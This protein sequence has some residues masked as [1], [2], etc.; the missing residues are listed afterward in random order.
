MR[1]RLPGELSLLTSLKRFIA[2]LNQLEGNLD[3]PF[4]GLTLLDTI[5]LDRNKISGT[6]PVAVLEHNP[7]LGVLNLGFNQMTGTLPNSLAAA[8]LSHLQLQSNEFLGTIPEAIGNDTRLRKWI[9]SIHMWQT[10]GSLTSQLPI[11][12]EILDLQNN[13]LEGTIPASV[14]DLEALSVFAITN[15]T[16]MN[17]TLDSRVGRLKALTRIEAGNT[18]MMGS[19][20]PELYQLTRLTDIVFG[21]SRMTGPLPE[22]IHLLNATLT[23]LHLQQNT[24]TGP[25]PQALDVLTALEQ[26]WLEENEFTGTISDKVCAERGIGYHK[27]FILNADCNIYCS[28]NDL[29]P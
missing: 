3:D 28:C 26:L 21:N 17:G 7:N 1:G 20:P 19:I 6:V 4:H 29:C 18:G 13:N 10:I 2:P 27:L 9:V 22:D 25:L 11:K 14:Y 5:V 8:K 23:I 16:H 15:N 12:T 24:F